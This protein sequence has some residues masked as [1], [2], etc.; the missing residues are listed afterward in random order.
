MN[1]KKIVSVLFFISLLVIVGGVVITLSSKCS[2]PDGS[3]YYCGTDFQ[4]QKI[5]PVFLSFASIL[6]ITSF[7]FFVRRET[8]LAWAKFAVVTFPLMLGVLLYTFNNE[9]T[10]GGFGL[11][12]LIPDELL[13]TFLLLPLFV[14]ISFII[15]V[16]K[17]WKLRKV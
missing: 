8:F 5:Q 12:G 11:A 7:L 10:P 13:A 17:S 3:T 15:I 14:I 16:Y 1:Q 6:L 2:F 9:P 4:E